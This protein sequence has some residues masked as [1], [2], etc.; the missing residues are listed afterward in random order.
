MLGNP[1][2]AGRAGKPCIE[3]KHLVS[4]EGAR[5]AQRQARDVTAQGITD[6]FREAERCA[7]ALDQVFFG[8]VTFD[9]AMTEYQRGRDERVL[10]MYELTCQL[11]TLEPPQ[12]EMQK[13]I[14]AIQGN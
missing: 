11:A 6:A 14:G 3:A 13:L 12:P 7:A 8:A 9:E 10:P 4:D 1:F 5:P 2:R